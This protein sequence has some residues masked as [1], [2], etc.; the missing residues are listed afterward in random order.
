MNNNLMM[1]SGEKMLDIING[2]T[3]YEDSIFK[4]QA[5]ILSGD[6]T[7]LV[8]LDP[9]ANIVQVFNITE[10]SMELI[11]TFPYSLIGHNLY[12][13]IDCNIDASIITIGD[14]ETV[15]NSN[16]Q[17]GPRMGSISIY[18]S[19]GA[20]YSLNQTLI[21]TY[22]TNFG[23]DT[24]ISDDS[25]I[26]ITHNRSQSWS[27]AKIYKTNGTSY[28]LNQTLVK[29]TNSSYEP[30]VVIISK[31]GLNLFLSNTNKIFRY[32]R[33]GNTTQFSQNYEFT[34]SATAYRI[35]NSRTNFEG[36]RIINDYVSH[37]GSIAYENELVSPQTSDL[38]YHTVRIKTQAN[39]LNNNVLFR[40]INSPATILLHEFDNLP[41]DSSA[42]NATFKARNFS[43]LNNTLFII[44]KG[45][46]NN[47][48]TDTIMIINKQLV[49]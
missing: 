47:A 44:Y 1:A 19:N 39:S 22:N 25:N 3:H 46:D 13:K 42:T 26:I 48:F 40:H 27:G 11:S 10:N 14:P 2:V 18:K 32:S 4:S 45:T 6:K 23:A 9:S 5:T 30:T 29:S 31:D 49:I 33:V 38:I 17:S 20:S 35:T 41:S 37:T 36:Q 43:V 15:L 16:G 7:K 28:S 21:G 34:R 8:S 12:L 24:S